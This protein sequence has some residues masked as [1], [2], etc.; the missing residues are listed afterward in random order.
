MMDA[1]GRWNVDDAI[2]WMK[3]LAKFKPTW[4]EEPTHPDD[5]LGHAKI[6]KVSSL[7]EETL[8]CHLF[9]I[10]IIICFD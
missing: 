2:S 1:N 4:I 9:K 10:F 5:V 8:L 7:L 3:K 6:A